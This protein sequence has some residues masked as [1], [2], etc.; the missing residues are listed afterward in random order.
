MTTFLTVANRARVIA[1]LVL[2]A[3]A[4]ASLV[5][6]EPTNTVADPTVVRTSAG[7]KQLYNF[8]IARWTAVYTGASLG[9]TRN[10]IVL[11]GLFTDELLRVQG[12]VSNSGADE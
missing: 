12:G 10:Q 2:G 4:P 8:A 7:A 9:D 11:S 1:A 6:V 5:D 3:C